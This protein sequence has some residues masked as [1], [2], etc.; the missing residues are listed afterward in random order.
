M[1]E[2]LTI[3]GMPTLTLNPS[4]KTP[5]AAL[6]EVETSTP[7]TLSLTL[8]DGDRKRALESKGA[9]TTNHRIP[10]LGLKPNRRHEI[11]V[12]ASDFS[13]KGCKLPDPLIVETAPLPDDFPELNVTVSNPAKMEP[14]HTVFPARL[15]EREALAKKFGMLIALDETGEVVWFYKTD[16]QIGSPH[17]IANGNIV[18]NTRARTSYEIDLLGNVISTW[19]AT[20]RWPADGEGIA[21]ATESFHHD[22]VELPNGNFLAPSIEIREMPDY[23]TSYTDPAASTDTA[24][25]IGD[26]I[27]EFQRDGTIVSEWPLLDMLDPYRFGFG[28]LDPR[29]TLGDLKNVRNWSHCNSNFYCAEDDTIVLSV[30]HQDAIV[31]FSRSTGE[32]IW[33]LGDPDGWQSPWKEKLL[34]PVGD[35]TWQYHQHNATRT[36]AGTIM[37]FDN[38]NYR[39]RPF[40]EPLPATENYSRAV[41]YEVDEEAMTVRQVWDYGRTQAEKYYATFVSG[42]VMLPKTQN[43]FV[44]FGGLMVD[45]DNRPTERPHVDCGYVRMAEVTHDDEPEIVFEFFMDERHGKGWDSYRGQ[46]IPNFF[47]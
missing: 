47:D 39:A 28:S 17:K 27:V 31:K 36:P 46:R 8:D 7:A 18:Y 3:I 37:C 33:I 35:V 42:A 40:A 45:G 30:R 24:N 21:V 14:G 32:L 13:G 6:L 19:H 15:S 4:G 22:L 38:G 9:P 44:D 43:V 29:G 23:P 26:V 34:T 5:L 41:E 20:G 2:N 12:R 1:A 11:G 25:V 10:I 16:H